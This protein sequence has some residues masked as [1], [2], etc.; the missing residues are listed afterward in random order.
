MYTY[1]KVRIKLNG[2]YRTVYR[3]KNLPPIFR[4]LQVVV[5]KNFNR[6]YAYEATTGARLTPNSWRGAHSNS[7]R[8]GVITIVAEYLETY[9]ES[10][11]EKAQE[12][13]NYPLQ[14]GK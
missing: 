7:T 6:W 11:W 5:L 13:L 2:K 12:T 10:R 3:V 1:R 8:N 9:H 4:G 14:K